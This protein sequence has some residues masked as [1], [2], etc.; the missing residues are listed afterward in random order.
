M[1][2]NIDAYYMH[3]AVAVR[4]RAN[5]LGRK[6]GAVLVR[7]NRIISTGYNGTPA[8]YKNCNDGGCIRCKKRTELAPGNYDIC[9]CVHAEQNCI[10]SAARF[11]SSTAG[12]TIYTTVRPCFN[13]TKAM[14]QTKVERV[15]YIHELDKPH[16]DDDIHEMYGEIQKRFELVK[17]DFEDPHHEWA[18]K[19]GEYPL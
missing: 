18:M 11:G 2:L 15:V 16:K 8:G 6:V 12:G 3:I 4:L 19:G 5:C 13:C 9:I 1:T 10:L 14:L 17:L 7:E